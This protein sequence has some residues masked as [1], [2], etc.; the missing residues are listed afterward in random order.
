M[1][2]QMLLAHSDILDCRNL[3]SVHLQ[4]TESMLYKLKPEKDPGCLSETWLVG[5]GHNW[6]SLHVRSTWKI[7]R[8]A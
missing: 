1:I 5:K 3:R 8:V 6:V 7:G 2:M 4:S